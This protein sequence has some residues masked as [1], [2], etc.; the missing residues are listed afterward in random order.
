[1]K[2]NMGLLVGQ[3]VG[4]AVVFGAILFVAAGT[5]AW[6]AGWA[7]LILFFGF[8]IALSAWLVR[9]N[10]A[11]LTERMGGNIQKKQATW[12]QI[13]IAIV[14]VVFIIW[15]LIM[16]LDAMRFQW[17]HVP[18]VLQVVGALLLVCSFPLF[19]AV[20]REN[21]FL[22]P[23]V[24]VQEE[25]GHSVISTGPYHY[26]RHPMYAAV[27]PWIFGI[28]LLL[29]SWVGVVFGCVLL[30]LIAQRAVMEEAT[31]R[32]ELQ[33]YDTYMTQVKYRLIPYV[34]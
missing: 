26:V 24:R 34:W 32:Q 6:A 16:P 7:F 30:L 11:L 2:V 4:M 28:A 20:F 8:V 33:G 10:P 22:S 15:L 5:V 12:D 17:S 27:I 29:G 19:F 23:V 25:R 9:N 18:G 1:V 13:L 31:L 3:I 21:S 14:S